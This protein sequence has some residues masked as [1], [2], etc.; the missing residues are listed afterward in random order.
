M[1]NGDQ[2]TWFNIFHRKNMPDISVM[3]FC[4]EGVK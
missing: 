2:F 3:F 4:G 1:D